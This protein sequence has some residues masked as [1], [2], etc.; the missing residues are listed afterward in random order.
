MKYIFSVLSLSTLLMLGAC[1]SYDIVSDVT[2]TANASEAKVGEKISFTVACNTDN[3]G[4]AKVEVI[5]DLSGDVL[6]EDD[7][8]TPTTSYSFDY[9]PSASGTIRVMFYAYSVN[10]CSGNSFRSDALWFDVTE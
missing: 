1:N 5:D 3:Y 2:L 9:T 7:S 8:I 4:C 6:F 10:R